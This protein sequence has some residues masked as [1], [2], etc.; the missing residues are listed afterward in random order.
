MAVKIGHA[1][2]DENGKAR[3]GNAG[4]QT[5]KEVCTRNWYSKGWQKLIRAKDPKVAE[6]IAKA[7]EDACAND[8]IGYDQY[9]RTTLFAQAQAN[10]W[11]IKDITT[12]CECDCSS[13]VAVCVNVAG[14]DV[15]KNIRTATMA[16]ALKATGAFTILTDAKYLNEDTYLQRGDIL[17]REYSHTVVVLSNGA[18]ATAS[19]SNDT[20]TT[21]AKPDDNSNGEFKVGD[22]VNFTGNKHYTSSYVGANAKPCR[23]GKAKIIAISKGK[24]HPYCLKAVTGEGSNVNGWVDASDIEGAKSSVLSHLKV[25]DIVEYS[26]NVHYTSSYAGAKAKSC[27]GGTAKVTAISKGKPHPY[28]LVH[29]GKGCTV[30][31]WVDADK[32]TK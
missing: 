6:K 10:K 16:N 31:G 4:D 32:V 19:S 8:N 26:G 28:C 11:K 1:S 15:D 5:K 22:V 7:I 17:V 13:L 20:A 18:K 24:V 25:G 14:V 9:Q 30:H 3:G 12:K 29:T 27:K 2:I 21:T 23:S